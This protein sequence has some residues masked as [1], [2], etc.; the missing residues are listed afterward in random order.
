MRSDVSSMGT[1]IGLLLEILT[2]PFPATDGD[3]SV[4]EVSIHCCSSSE[5]EVEEVSGPGI[6]K[7][8]LYIDNTTE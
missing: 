3:L 8:Y 5:A 6:I 2:A 7:H 1:E 4:G